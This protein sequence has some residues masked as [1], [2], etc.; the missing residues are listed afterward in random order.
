ML[1]QIHIPLSIPMP[2]L[3]G[4]APRECPTHP[5][6]Y[7]LQ[8]NP[9]AQETTTQNNIMWSSFLLLTQSHTN[10]IESQFTI[11]FIPD[12]SPSA[13]R[14]N[15]PRWYLL[16][17]TTQCSI[18]PLHWHPVLHQHHPSFLPCISLYSSIQATIHQR[19]QQTNGNARFTFIF[20][21]RFFQ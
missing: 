15:P 14:Y 20:P 1:N 3:D 16:Y 17:W 12:H 18:L 11:H 13:L 8:H 21:W 6:K 9:G 19:H 7:I 5:N 4:T 10:Q 2:P